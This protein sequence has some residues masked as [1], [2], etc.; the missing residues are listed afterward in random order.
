M[1]NQKLVKWGRRLYQAI[2]DAK[3]PAMQLLDVANAIRT[4]KK[5]ENLAP[6]VKLAIMKIAARCSPDHAEGAN[7]IDLGPLAARDEAANDNDDKASGGTT[8]G[9]EDETPRVA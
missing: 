4:Q 9:T 3:M 6:D 1:D 2:I 8:D 5:W 7:V